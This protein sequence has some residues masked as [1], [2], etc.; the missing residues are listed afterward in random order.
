M[1]PTAGPVPAGKYWIVNRPEGGLR[2]HVNAGVRDRY[3]QV[4]NGATFRHRRDDWGI[5]DDTWNEGVKRGNFRLH[6]GALSKGGYHS[7]T[8]FRFCHVA[9]CVTKNTAGGCSLYE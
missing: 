6:P 8:C 3:N 9:Q 1:K 4:M 7:A 2:S 5:D